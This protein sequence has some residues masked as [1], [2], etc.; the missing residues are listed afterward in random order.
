MTINAFDHEN[1]PYGSYGE[2]GSYDV[3]EDWTDEDW[4]AYDAQVAE[5]IAAY[6]AE[7]W[8]DDFYFDGDAETPF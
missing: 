5:D 8:A 3:T 1:T 7:Q 2:F 4:A 6:E